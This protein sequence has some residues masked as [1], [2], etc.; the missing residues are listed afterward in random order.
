MANVPRK[1]RPAPTANTAGSCLSVVN[2]GNAPVTKVPRKMP[3]A[4]R[5]VFRLAQKCS[6][7]I[8]VTPA[9]PASAE[10]WPRGYKTYFMLNS[11][12]NETFPAHKC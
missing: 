6:V 8:T 10:F 11:T 7:A 2:I 5:V 4:R 1:K 12:E 9:K 3:D